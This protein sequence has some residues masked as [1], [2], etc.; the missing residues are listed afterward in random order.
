MNKENQKT[1]DLIN[2]LCGDLEAAKPRSPYRNISIWLLLSVGYIVSVMLYL[3]VKVDLA[4]YFTR[5]PFIF[6]MGMAV[7]ILIS[8]AFA[9]S[10]LSFPDGLQRDW[11]KTIAVTLFASFLL[12]V[13]ASGI[14]E[15][16][17]NF[18][19]SFFMK[20]CSRGLFVEA[21]PFVVLILVTIRGNTTQP[22]WSMAMNV[23][24]VSA[25]GWIGLRV[26]CPMYESMTFGF[27]HY[28]LPFAI[29]GVGFG[30]FAR[31]IFKW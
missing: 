16:G 10:W 5:A 27:I 20:T 31:K 6:E 17:F 30:F 8:A 14:E 29:L 4:D 24:A 25:L 18:S 28:M 23:M 22:Y 1:D 11:M 13:V 9:S 19:S 26:T 12:W 21:I 3:G 15:G 2:Q 7:A